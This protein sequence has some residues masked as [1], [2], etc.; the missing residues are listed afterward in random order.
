[1]DGSTFFVKF[2][3]LRAK[4]KYCLMNHRTSPTGTSLANNEQRTNLHRHVVQFPHPGK[5]H[6]LRSKEGTMPWNRG[7]H[8]RKFM[9]ATGHCV[10]DGNLICDKELMFWGEWEPQS[11]YREI[12]K[13]GSPRYLHYPILDLSAEKKIDG[14][15]R[16][17]TDP[18]VFAD[19][20]YYRCCKQMRASRPTQLASLDRGSIILFGSHVGDAFAIDTV[21][22]VDESRPY[23][24]TLNP[25]ELEGFVPERY[26]DIVSIG[27]DKYADPSA[28]PGCGGCTPQVAS[29]PRQFRCYRGAT[30]E[31]RVNGMYSF[32][33]CRLAKDNPQGFERPII[34]HSDLDFISDSL[35]RTYKCKKDVSMDEAYEIWCKVQ[36]LC[37]RQE[38]LNGVRFYY[39]KSQ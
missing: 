19:A 5:E 15:I 2:N 12:N 7:G 22:V 34:K 30:F 23:P 25:K 6:L 10:E 24:D 27:Y 39:K 11:R 16:Q 31:N 28:S 29:V 13:N 26:A 21:F 9:Q 1:M 4:G 33:P 18:F 32:V 8:R 38:F 20:F 36:D 35:A 37:H 3:R 17:N 14:K